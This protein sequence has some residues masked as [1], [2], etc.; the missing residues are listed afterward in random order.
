MLIY[1][2][3]KESNATSRIYFNFEGINLLIG[4]PQTQ[5]LILQTI[6]RTSSLKIWIQCWITTT[7]RGR[8][9]SALKWSQR[10]LLWELDPV[11][12][13]LTQLSG[14]SKIKKSSFEAEMNGIRNPLTLIL[15]KTMVDI[16]TNHEIREEAANRYQEFREIA[17]KGLD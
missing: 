4:V 14:G 2:G 12:T 13:Q 9:E 6:K 17:E 5:V 11:V 15:L 1:I 10:W 16:G 3:C 7:Q 8:E